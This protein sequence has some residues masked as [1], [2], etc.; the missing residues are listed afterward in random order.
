MYFEQTMDASAATSSGTRS[1]NKNQHPG[2]VQIAAKRKRRTK[3]QIAADNAAQE[4]EKQE[5]GRKERDRIK[6]IASLEGEMAKKDTEADG[7][8][9]RSR[10]GDI[11]Y[12]VT[13]SRC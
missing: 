3:A 1:K 7:A 5:R 2:Q 4:A 10:N 13:L 9:P 11:S 6:N 12:L 8:H